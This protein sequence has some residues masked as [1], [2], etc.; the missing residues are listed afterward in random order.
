M[1]AL[2]A[3][4][5]LSQVQ[6][7]ERQVKKQENYIARLKETLDVAGVRYDKEVVQ[8][9]P[10]PDQMLQI[11]SKLEE[12]EKILDTMKMELLEFRL[13][14]IE[15]INQLDK[16]LYREILYYRYLENGNLKSFAETR[17]YS[18]SYVKKLHRIA[19]YLFEQKFLK[20]T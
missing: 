14:I 16:R 1:I 4:E 7:K 12:Q 13:S 15:K 9:S 6:S 19:L 11:L 5:Y 2:N 17:S 18:Y 3:K 8:S 20:N 10:E